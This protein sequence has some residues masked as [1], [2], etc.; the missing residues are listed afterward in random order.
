MTTIVYKSVFQNQVNIKFGED[1]E[2]VH[3]FLQD[4]IC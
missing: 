2:A 4:A 1:M 3:Q